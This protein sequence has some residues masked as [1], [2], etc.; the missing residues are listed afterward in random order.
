M[1]IIVQS[2]LFEEDLHESSSASR[3]FFAA[4]ERDLMRPRRRK[5]AGFVRTPSTRFRASALA[6]T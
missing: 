1:L 6:T 2:E 5:D 3:A 4:V